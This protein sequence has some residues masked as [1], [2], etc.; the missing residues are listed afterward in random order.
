[1]EQYKDEMMATLLLPAG[2]TSEASI[3]FKNEE[4]MLL[5]EDDVDQVYMEI[6]LPMKMKHNLRNIANFSMIYEI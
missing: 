6:I 1:M 3:L 4:R 2:V 5:N